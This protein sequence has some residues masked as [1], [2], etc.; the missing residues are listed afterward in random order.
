MYDDEFLMLVKADTTFIVRGN[1]IGV[2]LI[3]R[4][5]ASFFVFVKKHYMNNNIVLNSS[6]IHKTFTKI[7]ESYYL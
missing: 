5:V 4:S 2:K 6:K 1:G 3:I 7:Q